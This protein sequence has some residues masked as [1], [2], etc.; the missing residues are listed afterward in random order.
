MNTSE[1]TSLPELTTDSVRVMEHPTDKEARE[2]AIDHATA[3]GARVFPAVVFSQGQRRCLATAFP[4]S[5]IA[6]AVR[7]DP[8]KK[9]EDPRTATNRPLMADHVHG[10]Q[11]YLRSTQGK[12][13]ILPAITLNLREEPTLHVLKSNSIIKNGHLVVSDEAKFW[14]ADGQH[15]VAAIAGHNAGKRPTAGIL[16][17][18]PE[19]GRDG[20]GVIIVVEN[21]IKQI[22]QDFADAAQ[23]KQIPPSLL[24][25][26]NRRDPVNRVLDSIVMESELFKGRVDETS[27]TL[28]KM[29]Q[30]L[31]L[32]NQVRGM[33]KELIAKDYAMTDE[34]LARHAGERLATE[35]AQVEF[36]ERTNQ[37]LTELTKCMEPWNKIAQGVPGN[38]IPDLR[39]NYL[40]L[41]ASGLVIIGRVAYDI[42]KNQDEASRLALYRDLATK[43]D[44]RR[45]A[46]IWEGSVILKE[47]GKTKLMTQRGAINKAAQRVR[48]IL[49]L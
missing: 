21:D 49:N 46:E 35:E 32:L 9:G 8:A 11:A 12:R 27:K 40:N 5:F 6:R 37:L 33:L 23:T 44:W 43:I 7:V 42:D 38:Q 45:D 19:M 2:A 16:D 25:A 1:I 13:Y 28:P 26:Y 36:I 39:Q 17:D 29:S 4:L 18:I 14:V 48:E 10:I 47:G 20:I 41:S 3:T 24:A 22:H 31:F 15:R 30:K 34:Q